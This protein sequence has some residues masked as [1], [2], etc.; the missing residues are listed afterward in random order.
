MIAKAYEEGYSK[1]LTLLIKNG[2]IVKRYNYIDKDI[3]K[4]YECL[5]LS[6][7]GLLLPGFIDIHVHLR[8]LELSYKED[9]ES[10]TKAAIHGGFTAVIDMPNT[11]PR[12][13]NMYA[14]K[15]K[16]EALKKRSY[17]DF[18]LYVS[19]ARNEEELEQMLLEEGVIGVKIFPQ[20]LNQIG[21]VVKTMKKVSNRIKKIII[22]HAE[23][24]LMLEDCE[25]GR[26]WVCRPIESEVSVLNKLKM[27]A[28]REIHIHITH[29]TNILTL[30]L[31]KHYGFTV[32]TC[33]HYIYMDA[34]YEKD[35]KCIA[36]VNPPLR[37]YTT[38]TILSDHL[39]LFDAISS[40]HAPHS[41]DEKNRDFSDCPPGITSLD[42]MGSLVLNMVSKNL[43]KLGDVVKLVSRGPA[44]ILGIHRWGCLY[45]GCIA[46]YTIVDLDKEVYVDPQYFFS[47]AKFTPYKSIRLRGAVK[48]TIVRGFLAYIEE[49]IV[50]K[51][52]P[53]PITLFQRDDVCL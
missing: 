2:I 35:M 29:V 40:D 43:I 8:G 34:D 22:V 20:D 23:N 36:K 12:I 24:P 13:D 38:R 9:E 50:E 18:G 28:D 52:N 4:I 49:S 1:E 6:K 14:L 25:A 7:T 17:V 19:P 32:D 30:S 44:N 27:F 21:K 37:L 46:S 31:A 53:L 11:I 42:I 10:G 33:P 47:K 3:C 15:L 48:A 39:N 16:L 5:D 41:L 51:I 45:E 26:R